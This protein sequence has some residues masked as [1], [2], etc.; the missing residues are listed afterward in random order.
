MD[1]CYNTL[2]QHGYVRPLRDYHIQFCTP[3]VGTTSVEVS[4]LLNCKGIYYPVGIGPKGLC[5][6]MLIKVLI[7]LNVIALVNIRQT[8]E[9]IVTDYNT[10]NRIAQKF[11][12]FVIFFFTLIRI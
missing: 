10:Q 8:S 7:M 2:V 3:L 1:F 6:A 11:K 5:T 12:T 4:E 9:Y